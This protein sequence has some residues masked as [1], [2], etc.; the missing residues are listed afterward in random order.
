MTMSKPL[1]GITCERTF[2]DGYHWHRVEEHYPIAV[3][4]TAGGIPVLI[5]VL[6]ARLDQ[7]ALLQRLDGLLLTGGASNIEPDLY[8]R[9]SE[10]PNS[11]RDRLRDETV[12]ALIPRAIELGVP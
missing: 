6:A 5:P 4:E 7:S 1:I 9:L 3:I 2:T 11:P 8:D 10:Q 12:L